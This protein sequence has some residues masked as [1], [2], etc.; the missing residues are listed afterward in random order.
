MLSLDALFKPE[1]VCNL[2]NDITNTES[3]CPTL[4]LPPTEEIQALQHNKSDDGNTVSS[5]VG[6]N[7]SN[8]ERYVQD[9]ENV[10]EKKQPNWMTSDEF[11]CPVD[12]QELKLNIMNSQGLE[13]AEKVLGLKVKL[14]LS[15]IE[16]N[17]CNKH[18]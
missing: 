5:S 15:H 2:R 7:G 4:H 16:L 1:V 8:S 6:S 14:S 13:E 18:L 3:M 12:K 10:R 11:I 17:V 9:L